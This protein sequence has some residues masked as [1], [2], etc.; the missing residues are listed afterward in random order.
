MEIILIAAMASNKVIGKNNSIPWHIPEEFKHFKDTTMGFPV[1]MGRRTYESI[2]S[3]LPGRDNIV[4]TSGQSLSLP[5]CSVVHNLDEALKF[6]QGHQKVF[7]IGGAE[8]F[9]LALPITD[10]ILLTVL[11]REIE[12]DTWFPDFSKDVFI[13]TENKRVNQTEPFTI[14]TYRR[15]A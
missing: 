15:K 8:I 11:D 7:I 12:G 10:T 3:S 14:Y 1:I 13:E 2:G 6:C 5:G 9:K 4:I